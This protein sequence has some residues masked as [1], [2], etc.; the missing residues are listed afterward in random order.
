[1][2]AES[3]YQDK[4]QVQAGCTLVKSQG[5]TLTSETHQCDADPR[6]IQ[7][8]LQYT[9]DSTTQ[10]GFLR[11]NARMNFVICCCAFTKA[12]QLPSGNCFL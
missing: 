9:V 4:L 10:H 1:M 3:I 7:H 12:E 11:A 5:L 2:Q 8:A 6:G